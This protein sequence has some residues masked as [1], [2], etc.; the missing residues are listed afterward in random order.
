M[1]KGEDGS[2]ENA[3]TERDDDDEPGFHYVLCWIVHFTFPPERE[4]EC[5]SLVYVVCDVRIK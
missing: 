2:D 5:C 4:S 3:D 1:K